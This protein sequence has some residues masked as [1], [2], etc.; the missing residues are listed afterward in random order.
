MTKSLDDFLEE[1]IQMD[2]LIDMAKVGIECEDS[3]ISTRSIALLYYAEIF[4][5]ELGKLYEKEV[6]SE[7][8]LYKQFPL[9]D[10]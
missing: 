3:A 5:M 1:I 10:D 7:E 6:S 4:Q 9:S 8:K 2:N